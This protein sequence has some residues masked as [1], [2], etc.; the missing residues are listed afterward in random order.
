MN[1]KRNSLNNKCSQLEKNMY[2]KREGGPHQQIWDKQVGRG[3]GK[4]CKFWLVTLFFYRQ[5]E[6]LEN[7]ELGIQIVL[8]KSH[9]TNLHS[10]YCIRFT[11]LS[12]HPWCPLPIISCVFTSLFPAFSPS[13]AVENQLTLTLSQLSQINVIVPHKSLP[14]CR[15]C[16]QV[17]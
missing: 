1:F 9:Q 17:G 3:L 7:K 10:A 5:C 2:G 4:G 12:L 6:Q 14:A 13:E 15:L 8:L 16:S 11:W